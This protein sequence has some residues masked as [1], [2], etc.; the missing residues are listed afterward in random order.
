MKKAIIAGVILTLLFAGAAWNIAHLDRLT[1]G[2]EAQLEA[3]RRFCEAGDFACARAELQ[4]AIDTWSGADG[5]THI[6]IRH[7]EINST[8]DAFYDLLSALGAEDAAAAGGA[9]GK[10]AAQLKS[11]DAME[12][13]T[14][15]SIF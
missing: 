4:K 15:K 9:Y 10:V 7:A 11:I 13:V 6:F 12:H 14:V 5:Y 2:L 8:T 1:G 3:S